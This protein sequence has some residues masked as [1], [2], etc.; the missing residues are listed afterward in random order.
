MNTTVRYVTEAQ[1]RVDDALDALARM[2]LG[3]PA[4]ARAEQEF[5]D[6][7]IALKSVRRTWCRNTHVP[8]PFRTIINQFA[9]E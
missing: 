2:D 1:E 7:Q 3:D 8:E 5:E 9:G 6:A 4:Y